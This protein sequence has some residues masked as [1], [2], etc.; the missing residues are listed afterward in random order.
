MKIGILGAGLSGISLAYFLQQNHRISSIEILEQ[1]SD[2]GG[3][4]RSFGF[5]GISYDIGPHIIFS[6]DQNILNLMVHVLGDNVKEHRRSNKICYK[7]R[8]IK[9]PL[10]ND[11]S[12]LPDEDKDYCLKTFLNNPHEKNEAKTLLQY[13]LK[14]FGE[15]ITRIY[16]KPYNEKI[17]KFDPSLMDT[18][19]AGRIPKPPAEDIIK[20]A[21]GVPSEG[22]LHQLYFYYPRT[23]GIS[24]LVKA[25]ADQL[26]DNVSIVVESKVVELTRINNKWTVK[27]DKGKTGKYDV[28]ISTIPVPL[29]AGIYRPAVPEEIIK[30]AHALRY[31][32]IIIAVINVKKDNLG[33]NFAV[34]IPDK[35]IIFHR[36]S[37]LNFLGENYRHQ[38]DS[39]TLMAEIT[40]SKDSP[41]DKMSDADVRNEIIKGLEGIQFIDSREHIRWIE[42]RRIEYAYVINDL[43]HKTNVNR[44]RNYFYGQ[45]IRL[46][47]RFGEFEYLNMDAVVSHAQ[48]LSEEIGSNI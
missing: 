45:G 25:F 29:L 43:H 18:Q 30:A 20:S 33:D 14:T 2:I 37:K 7:N 34:M 28:I 19:M 9:Y 35:N 6:K 46:C 4:C 22:Y 42:T 40:Y 44:V 26:N 1:A 47:G 5:N 31:N 38:D 36:V 12:A 17:W 27:T 48:A 41:I 13:F 11:L 39:T 10:E 8:L 24:S 15:G 3:L 16:L 32:S 23:G 21:S